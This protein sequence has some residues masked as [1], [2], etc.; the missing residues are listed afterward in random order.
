MKRNPNVVKK[1]RFFP[2]CLFFLR[3]RWLKKMSK[4]GWHLIDYGIFVYIFE[5]GVP[6]DKEYFSYTCER[7]GDGKYSIPLR[8]PLLDETFGV[9]K[10]KSKLNK[11][12]IL[13]SKANT[14]I[15]VDTHKIDIENDI[16][17]KELRHDRNKLYFLIT[18]R[19]IAIILA[20]IVFLF[21]VIHLF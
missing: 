4:K 2:K 18:I 19:N 3:D 8:Y 9:K 17:Y 10:K 1:I 11:N 20:L 5:N 21:V 7:V 12:S 16:G 14:I 6:S 15:E 13:K